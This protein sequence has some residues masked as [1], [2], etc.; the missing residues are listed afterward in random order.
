MTSSTLARAG[1][2]I[3]FVAGL[4][5]VVPM[6]SAWVERFY[7]RQSYL[8]IQNLVTPLSSLAPF[9]VFDLLLVVTAVALLGWWVAALVRAGRGRRWRAA[10][11]MAF[12]TM[13]VL[14]GIY[15]VFL[16]G[17]GFNYRRE[18]LTAKLDYDEHRVNPDALADLTVE[19]VERLNA[20][21]PSAH[22]SEWPNLGELPARLGPAFEQ[23]QRQ[24]GGTR[25]AVT[26]APK[27]SLL[28][29]YFRL[30]GVDGMLNPFSLE[31]LVNDTVLRFERPFVVAHEWAHLAGYA[32]ES[33]ASFVG[34][35]TC[36]AGD[37]SSRYS[38]W[39]FLT[40]HLMRYLG[41]EERSSV[42]ALMDAGPTEDLRAVAERVSQTMPIVQRN[43]NRVYDRYLKANR[44]EAGI[45]SYG[46]VVDLIL[47][48]KS[49]QGD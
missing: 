32:D 30:A 41:E 43:A 18:P 31:V 44:V 23:V 29:P 38:G 17:W 8:V 21:Y 15:V 39:L 12:K 49:W 7:S 42:W 19:S 35:L 33:E 48:T 6:P 1:T 11:G 25:T 13:S 22:R 37:E 14:A 26:G 34:W 46:A 47:G 5:A 45:A 2:L 4:M 20:L 24:L 16:L 28:T 36:L 3:I 27:A 40:P 9:A 10:A